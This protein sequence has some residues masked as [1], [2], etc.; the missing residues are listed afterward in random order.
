MVV[1]DKVSSP[2][3]T[4][5]T[6]TVLCLR[7]GGHTASPRVESETALRMESTGRDDETSSLAC[8][9]GGRI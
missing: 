5:V 4:G 8:G 1:N 2:A 7:P 3:F 6:V 9:Q